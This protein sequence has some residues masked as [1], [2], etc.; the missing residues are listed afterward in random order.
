MISHRCECGRYGLVLRNAGT[1]ERE[2]RCVRCATKEQLDL[3]AS[4]DARATK[5]IGPSNFVRWGQSLLW[6]DGARDDVESRVAL[7]DWAERHDVV[8]VNR[9]PCLHWLRGGR[10]CYKGP[11]H[12]IV[13]ND[14][15]IF[16]AVKNLTAWR[17]RKSDNRRHRPACIIA[18][19]RVRDDHITRFLA[20]VLNPA[21]ATDPRLR[22]DTTETPWHVDARSLIAVWRVNE[23]DA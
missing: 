17:R 15:L 22:V 8:H 5:R 14:S 20:D 7:L 19:P 11:I 16:S 18:Q 3:V 21:V 1:G 9:N 10:C 12:W 13:E 6:P 2:A 23:W 4:I